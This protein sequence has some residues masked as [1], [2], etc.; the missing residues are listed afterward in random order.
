LFSPA[1]DFLLGCLAAVIDLPLLQVTVLILALGV[2]SFV[3]ASSPRG[4]IL[5]RSRDFFPH[6]SSVLIIAPLLFGFL[7][8]TDILSLVRVLGI[9]WLISSKFLLRA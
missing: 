4:Q 7:A 1:E 9:G 8:V 5:S 2:W 6:G 3:P